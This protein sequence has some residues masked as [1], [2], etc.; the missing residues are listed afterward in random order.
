MERHLCRLGHRHV[1]A[2]DADARPAALLRAHHCADGVDRL[3][4]LTS[5]ARR[6]AH[7]GWRP[8]EVPL[9]AIGPLTN[10]ARALELEPRLTDWLCY[11]YMLWLGIAVPEHIAPESLRPTA[12][13]G[14]VGIRMM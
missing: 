1:R 5:L 11:A 4:M 12:A 2:D 10:V 14:S 7:T 6:P 9:I 3:T 13:Y 8:R